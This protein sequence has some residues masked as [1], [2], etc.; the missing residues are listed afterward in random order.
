MINFS[1]LESASVVAISHVSFHAKRQRPFFCELFLCFFV[2][3]F[4][5]FSLFLFNHV[6]FSCFPL[7]AWVGKVGLARRELARAGWQGGSWQGGVGKGGLGKK[8]MA[9]GGGG[10]ALGVKELRLG[11]NSSKGRFAIQFANPKI[12]DQ[13]R[14][15][16]YHPNSTNI[17]SAK[18]LINPGRNGRLAKGWQNVGNK[19]A[20]KRAFRLLIKVFTSKRMK[21][22]DDC[23][24]TA[25]L[26]GGVDCCGSG[27]NGDG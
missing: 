12:V 4:R 7:S 8:R 26:A 18:T 11:D 17:L 14:I 1:I 22:D 27:A 10:L 13:Q 21:Y 2:F 15:F 16:R 6:C 25:S 20:I 3:V 9:R 23:I 5:F 19:L 24:E